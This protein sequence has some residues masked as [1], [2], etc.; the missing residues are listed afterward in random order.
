MRGMLVG[1]RGGRGGG[2]IKR[3]IGVCFTS[4][5]S[6]IGKVEGVGRG[7]GGGV[8]EREDCCVDRAAH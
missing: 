4:S 2:K 6:V 3:R 5:I 8:E 7:G 1:G